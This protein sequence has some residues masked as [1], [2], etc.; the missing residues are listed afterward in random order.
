VYLDPSLLSLGEDD[1]T[2]GCCAARCLRRL[3][4]RKPMMRAARTTSGTMT[5]AAIAPAEMPLWC[6]ETTGPALLDKVAA[7]CDVVA[8]A[9]AS[10]VVVA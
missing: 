2:V 3:K 8:A 5:A 10:G 4:R 7:G 9:A 1:E 6:A